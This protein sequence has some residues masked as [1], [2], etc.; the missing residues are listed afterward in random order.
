MRFK[1]LFKVTAV[2]GLAGILA[3]LVAPTVSGP[4]AA[5]HE[6]NNQRNRYRAVP[7]AFVGTAAQCGGPAGSNIV[8]SAWLPGMGLPDDGASATDAASARTDA[9]YGLLLSKNGLTSNCS[10]AGARITGVEGITLTELGFDYRKG[11]HCGAGAPRFNVTS[12][13][14]FTYFFGCIYGVH[15]PAPQD[16]QWER[17]RFSAVD[18]APAGASNPPFVFGTGAGATRVRSISIVLDEGT[19]IVSPE[20]P[21]GVGLA[22]LDN[23][24]IS[25]TLIT[26][27]RGIEPRPQGGGDDND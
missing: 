19:D 17:V 1:H 3:F 13:A 25:G 18:A 12:T 7:F 22:V 23:I 9:R 27:G 21:Q 24:D 11:G 16:P 14:G 6:Q 8:T 4:A 20:D 15:T 26:R 5:D 2:L 10:S